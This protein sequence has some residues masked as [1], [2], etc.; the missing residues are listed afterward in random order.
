M[1]KKERKREEKNPCNDAGA[2]I[3][4]VFLY[5]RS[6]F[7]ESD[8]KR[9]SRKTVQCVALTRF[10]TETA[11]QVKSMRIVTKVFSVISNLKLNDHLHYYC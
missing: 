5:Y 3:L 2:T 4:K 10:L 1:F 9:A 11:K 8:F 7:I 6:I